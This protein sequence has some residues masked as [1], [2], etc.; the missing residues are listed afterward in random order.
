MEFRVLQMAEKLVNYPT[1]SYACY[2]IKVCYWSMHDVIFSNKLLNITITMPFEY[3]LF[4]YNIL[5]TT[6]SHM[7]FSTGETGGNIKLKFSSKSNW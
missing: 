3:D 6:A 5:I 4:Y 1:F 2:L 7:Q